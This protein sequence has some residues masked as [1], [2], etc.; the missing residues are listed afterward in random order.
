MRKITAGNQFTQY[1]DLTSSV[2]QL[3]SNHACRKLGDFL[4]EPYTIKNGKVT[5]SSGTQGQ[6]CL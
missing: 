2:S 4:Y 5:S 1:N 6:H 3:T